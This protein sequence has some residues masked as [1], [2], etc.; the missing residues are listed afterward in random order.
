MYNLKINMKAQMKQMYAKG[1][2]SF[3]MNNFSDVCK[4]LGL[5]FRYNYM[6]EDGKLIGVV[7][8]DYKDFRQN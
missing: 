7:T 5:K 6:D 4:L 1:K 2:Y 8:L 3:G